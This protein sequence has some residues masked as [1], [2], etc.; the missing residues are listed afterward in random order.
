MTVIEAMTEAMEGLE[1]PCVESEEWAKEPHV[2][3]GS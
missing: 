1:M 3:A 2:A